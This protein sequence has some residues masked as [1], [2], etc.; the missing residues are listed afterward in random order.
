[1]LKT[2]VRSLK[3]HYQ[4]TPLL[5]V[6]H[7]CVSRD[8]VQF[9]LFVVQTHLAQTYPS[10][11]HCLFLILNTLAQL[12]NYLVKSISIDFINIRMICNLMLQTWYLFEVHASIYLKWRQVTQ[13]QT[14]IEV[15]TFFT[16]MGLRWQREISYAVAPIR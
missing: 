7:F 6:L 16:V 15:V 9:E 13:P 12:E 1:M 8:F 5:L 14:V 10:L 2:S 3:C 4:I 11:S